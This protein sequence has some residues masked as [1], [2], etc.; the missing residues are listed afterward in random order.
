MGLCHSLIKRQILD[1]GMANADLEGPKASVSTFAH[2]LH[3]RTTPNEPREWT[4]FARVAG[5]Q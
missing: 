2:S 1:E 4:D 3:K 5:H